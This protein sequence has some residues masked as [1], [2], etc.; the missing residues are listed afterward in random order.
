MVRVLLDWRSLRFKREF[1]TG[2]SNKET[3]PESD[4]VIIVIKSFVILPC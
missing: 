4:Y 2:F 1:N 3:F